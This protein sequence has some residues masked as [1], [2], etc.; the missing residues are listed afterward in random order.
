MP[1]SNGSKWP[2]YLNVAVVVVGAV[3]E[4]ARAYLRWSASRSGPAA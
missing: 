2:A 4:A 3:L 1:L